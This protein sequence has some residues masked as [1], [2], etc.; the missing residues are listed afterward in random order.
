ML[1]NFQMTPTEWG[2]MHPKERSFLEVMAW[3]DWKE[4]KKRAEEANSA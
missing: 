4:Q 2:A 3:S 1:Q